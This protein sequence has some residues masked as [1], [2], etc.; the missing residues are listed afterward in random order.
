M[1]TSGR[2][3]VSQYY[4]KVRD[5]Y[6]RIAQIEYSLICV[7][8]AAWFEPMV[9]ADDWHGLVCD[10]NSE[11][12]RKIVRDCI[13]YGYAS[14]PPRKEQW[15]RPKS[16]RYTPLGALP[17]APKGGLTSED[18][19]GA[20]GKSSVRQVTRETETTNAEYVRDGDWHTVW[21]LYKSD[22]A[23]E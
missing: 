23:D 18:S 10:P 16:G 13:E 17:E 8:G 3:E 14:L 20:V 21:L 7:S 1:E 5:E 4:N 6:I 19:V 15:K 9:M 11:V 12:Y 2:S 22:A